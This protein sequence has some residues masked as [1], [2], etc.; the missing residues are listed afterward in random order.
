MG[1]NKGAVSVRFDLGATSLCF[2]NAH[3]AAGQAHYIE[4]CQHFKLILQN[5]RFRES[6][7]N[8]AAGAEE[9]AAG[10][11]QQEAA[12]A[13]SW[14]AATWT[15][16]AGAP[17]RG[18]LRKSKSAL[19]PGQSQIAED[20]TINDHDHVFWIGD[21]N[22]RLHW[23]GQLGGM[24]IQQAVQKVQDRRIGDLLALDQLNISR[25]DGLAFDGFD[26]HQI[27]FLPSYKWRPNTD[28]LDVR[29]QKH[30]PA[31]CDRILW[32]SLVWPSAKMHKYDIH[33][34]LRQSDH[35]PVFA[36]GSFKAK[37][38]WYSDH[39]SS[40]EEGTA[41]SGAEAPCY[42]SDFLAIAMEPSEVSFRGVK[43][44]RFQECVVS[45][46]FQSLPPHSGGAGYA[47]I[48]A[49]GRPHAEFRSGSAHFKVFA[50]ASDGSVEPLGRGLARPRAMTGEGQREAVESL[51]LTR[52]LCTSPTEG[53]VN[54][55]RP[56]E[57][58]VSLCMC[59]AV[60][61]RKTLATA[62]VVRV[63]DSTG[64]KDFKLPVEALLEPSLLRVP[65][66]TLAGLGDRPL[67]A[68][69]LTVRS[70]TCPSS[71]GDGFPAVAAGSVAFPSPANTP[72]LPPKEAMA[73]MQWL[74][75]RSRDAA[76]GS[77][78]WWP[79]PLHNSVQKSRDELAEVQRCL[80][81]GQPLPLEST[82]MPA[83]SA[84]LF[85]LRWL[86]LL[87]IP[88]LTRPCLEMVGDGGADACTEALQELLELQRNVVLCV[89]CLFA[90]LSRRHGE[91]VEIAKRLTECLTQQ[92]PPPPAGERLLTALLLEFE[93]SEFP[94]LKKMGF[95]RE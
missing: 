47:H 17:Y 5:I 14:R 94:P 86:Q 92:A 18:A 7:D 79:D 2:V 43:P 89:A 72:L 21:T 12:S 10:S 93:R 95:A 78:E 82:R 67:L 26:E 60:M 50:L 51:Q 9:E 24:P 4:R 16:D 69:S 1:G 25:H 42:Q 88:I 81:H 11:P 44:D 37:G 20:L 40:E 6:R 83:R 74:L 28:E 3:L 84:T 63:G 15:R 30:I 48:A 36:C 52:W 68:D 66:D 77:L 8:T 91:N 59:E 58:R 76:P 31:W 64:S 39:V 22:S 45:L 87:P 61:R 23:P 62:L 41:P 75:Q 13:K 46:T 57:L 56:M 19:S 53:T 70:D 55:G 27:R 34:G 90:Q 73:V 71:F 49:R 32:K 35:R 29:S 85:L 38:V 33:L 65:L 80:E 54:E